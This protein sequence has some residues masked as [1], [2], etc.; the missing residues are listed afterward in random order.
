MDWLAIQT[1]LKALGFDPGPLDGEPGRVTTA[2]VAAFQKANAVSVQ[3][4]GTVGDKTLAALFS[5]GAVPKP[6]PLL[7]YPW[8]ELAI[9]KKGLHEGRN[10]KELAAF[11]KSDGRT[12]GD[13]RRLP[14]CGDFIETCLAITL[15]TEP[16][17]SNPYL[18]RNWSKMGRTV[19]PTIGAVMSFWRTSKTQS[20][21]GHVAFAVG[22]EPGFFYVLGG[23]QS[24]A[25]SVMKLATD[26]LL[27]ARWPLTFDLPDALYL[28][29]MTGGVLSLNEA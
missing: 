25:I 16:L 28:P 27:A 7:A 9:R 22:Q 10:Y 17:P 8:L 24:D 13:P 1:R 20:T 4:P 12:L 2:A 11:L 15:P 3:W 26:R 6:N 19:P 23:N 14:W 5:G 21:D 18:A 29:R